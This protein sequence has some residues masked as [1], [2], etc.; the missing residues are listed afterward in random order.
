MPGYFSV[1]TK[2][3]RGYLSS[4]FGALDLKDGVEGILVKEH[5]TLAEKYPTPSYSKADTQLLFLFCVIWKIISS[6]YRLMQA[7][8][9]L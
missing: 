1:F 9:V 3:Y 8:I 5:T 7:S 6:C 2:P 4:S